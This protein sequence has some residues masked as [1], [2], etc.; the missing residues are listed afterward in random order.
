MKP[1]ELIICIV[2]IIAFIWLIIA[3]NKVKYEVWVKVVYEDWTRI[4]VHKTLR[5]AKR[6]KRELEEENKW[7]LEQIQITKIY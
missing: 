7:L 3:L 6:K 4:S 5:D 1:T 2:I